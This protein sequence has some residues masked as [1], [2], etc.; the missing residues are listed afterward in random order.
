MV[1]QE[2]NPFP[3]SNTAMVLPYHAGET[4]DSRINTCVMGLT[5]RPSESEQ[6]IGQ[7][8]TQ[9]NALLRESYKN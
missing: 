5:H 4:E 3:E 2:N 6:C 7:Y 1:S 8:A 9:M